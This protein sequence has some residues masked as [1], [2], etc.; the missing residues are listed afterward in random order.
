MVD[1]NFNQDILEIVL[2]HY[3]CNLY[4]QSESN[5]LQYFLTFK[6]AVDKDID[7]T[8]SDLG[9]YIIWEPFENTAPVS[10]LENM[11][12]LYDDIEKLLVT[13]ES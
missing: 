1:V 13:Y 9:N 4:E 10:V 8:W 3:F 2:S 7:I 5:I 12:A 6:E 11:L